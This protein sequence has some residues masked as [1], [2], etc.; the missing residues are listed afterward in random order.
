MSGHF[1]AVDVETANS[2][3][4][5]ICQIGLVSFADGNIAWEW[6]SLVNPEC[7]FDGF[8]VQ[9]HG[10][11]S[12]HVSTAP[13]W[14]TVLEQITE[15]ISGQI[16]VSHTSFDCD[17]LHHAS[18]RYG[19]ALPSCSWL[20]TCAVARMAWPEL[21]HHKLD[22]LCEQF[23]IRLQHHDAV[24]DARACGELLQLANL[25]TGAS[26]SD[27]VDRTGLVSPAPYLAGVAAA[28]PRY[29][30][31]LTCSANPSGQLGNQV[32]VCT[33][34]FTS[35]KKALF[36]MAQALGCEVNERVTDRTTM[37]VF[38][39]RN[40]VRFGGREKSRKQLDAEAAISRGQPVHILTEREFIELAARYHVTLPGVK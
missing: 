39:S 37:L 30:E 10:I 28:R 32:W 16:V 15:S 40:V 1:I 4:E 18:A 24:S 5:S 6:S 21:A 2:S 33:G 20:D 17:A 26:V 19:I 8:N 36:E 31:H 25:H 23:G 3:R 11:G 14:S 29:T 34:E 38:G 12:A 35:G 27:W 9:L 22:V 7:D 13:T